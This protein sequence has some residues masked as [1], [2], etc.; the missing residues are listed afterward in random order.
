MKQILI[1]GANGMI[2]SAIIPKLINKYKLILVDAYT[3]RIEK[4][5]NRATVIKSDFVTLSKRQ[6]VLEGVYC[7]VHLAA[8]VHWV[9]KTKREELQFIQ[10]NVEGS[11]M[12]YNA[13]SRQGVARFLFFSTN[14]VYAASDALITEETA[15]AP[16]G[17]YGK[18]KFL[19]EE[20][21]REASLTSKTAVC[22]FRP[23]SVYGENDKG[24]M[25]SL[26]TFCRRGLVPMIGKGENKKALLYLKDIAQAVERYLACEKDHNGEV[27][28][29][30]SGDYTYRGIIDTV[31]GI[32]GLKPL[33]VYVPDWFCKT[34]APKISPLKKL[35]V[36]GEVKTI[37]NDKALK[38]MGYEGTYSLEEGLL[39]AKGYYMGG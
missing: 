15:T 36:A 22:I 16:R 25:L 9:P 7:V 35:A 32:Y 4:Y 28:N 1:T 11:R 5:A 38:L 13:C 3:N 26:I 24:S 39:D 27:F 37:S 2:G 17:I 20:H 10:T 18:S 21:L 14:D 23:A 6:E 30:S 33:R 8:A 29:I 19:A 34:V 12:I 31:C